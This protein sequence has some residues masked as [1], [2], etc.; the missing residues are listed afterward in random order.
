[1]EHHDPGGAAPPEATTGEEAT[2]EETGKATGE[3]TIETLTTA[4]YLA[5]RLCAER[6]FA[7][8]TVAEAAPLAEA[9]DLVLTK[10]DGLSCTVVCILDGEAN[11]GRTFELTRDQ[12]V[13]VGKA[14][15]PYSGTMNGT[16]LPVAIQIW[17]VGAGA[18]GPEALRRHKAVARALPGRAKVVISG[19]GIDPPR[20]EVRTTVVF[21]GL[22]YGR[23]FLT[24]ALREPRLTG[25]ELARR[26]AAVRR[27]VGWPWVT[28][29]L[30]ALLV[31]I[32][33]G[34]VRTSFGG[35]SGALAPTPLTLVAWGGLLRSL[36]FEGEWHRL[37]TCALVHADVLHLLLNG[38][39]LIMAGAVLETLLGRAWLLAL[40]VLGALGG[41]AM[42]LALNPGDL[43][44]VGA[45]GAIMG[46]LAAGIFV[47]QRLPS[48]A[49]RLRVQM[50]LLYVLLPSLI[51]LA[52]RG[53]GRV[54]YAGHL[55]GALVGG[56]LGWLI[57]RTWPRSDELPRFRGVAR[58]VAAAGAAALVLG[59]ALLWGGRAEMRA[60]AVAVAHDAALI[61]ADELPASDAELV[62]RSDELVARYP[63]D[64]RGRLAQAVKRA[65]AGDSAGAQQALRAALAEDQLLREAFVGRGLEISLRHMLAT[66]LLGEQRRAEAAA[67]VAPVCVAGPG[68]GAPDDIRALDLCP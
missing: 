37:L 26:P 54:D 66:L 29:A 32:F 47:A 55:G 15:L 16:K 2:G 6:G 13:E 8:G 56:A 57:L 25:P 58:G 3:A 59:G 4:Q 20:G 22:L 14:C 67:V 46:M 42:S 45:S 12:I 33:A 36:V 11:P 5:M 39:A 17:E 30:A 52:T 40:F 64:P 23:P 48:E 35:T 50:R 49:E 65:R 1:M 34:E 44:S 62:A 38:V 41:S 63:R 21:N 60:A 18:T 24:R 28:F 10:A 19:W 7:P 31:G 9:C 68:G 53:G 27:D 61:P 43:V 51:P